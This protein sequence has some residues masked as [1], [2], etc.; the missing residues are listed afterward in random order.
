MSFFDTTAPDWKIAWNDNGKQTVTL[1]RET[2]TKDASGGPTQT[3][4]NV[5]GQV[6]V[7]CDVQPA[8]GKVIAR[9]LGK[10]LVVQYTIYLSQDIGARASDRLL[11]GTRNFQVVEGG[12]ITG[13]MAGWP[14]TAFVQEVPH[15]L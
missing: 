12:Y 8:S 3:W 14:A 10:G 11:F 1:E 4:A 2:T 7:P 6:N 5:A 13:D 9:F 15:S